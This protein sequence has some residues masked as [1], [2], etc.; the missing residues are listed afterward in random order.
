MSA[1]KFGFDTDRVD[2]LKIAYIGGGSR[3][4]ARALMGDLASEPQMSGEVRLYDIDHGAAKANEII[5]N[6]LKNH[7]GAKGRWDYQAKTSLKD[8]LSGADF[9]VISILP[10]TFEEMQSDVH[11]PEKY[12]IYHSVG[13]TSGPAGI[14]RAMRSIPMFAEIAEAARAYCPSAWV[15]NYTNPMSVCTGAL[16]KIFPEI[17][18]FGCCHEVFH[19]QSVLARM[20]DLDC[21]IKNIRRDEITVNVL[22]IN[23]FTWVTQAG[24]KNIDLMPMFKSFAEKYAE[25]GYAMSEGDKDEN[26]YFRNNNKVCFDLFRRF[27]SAAIPCAGDRHLAEFMPPWYLKNPETVAQWGFG[28]TP[29]PERKKW[30]V[31]HLKNTE[32]LVAGEET[33]NPGNSGEEGTKQIRA[34]LG[35]AEFVTNVNLPNI[36]QGENLPLGAM[37]ETNA[38]FSRDSVRPVFA[39]KL[40][41][42]VNALVSKHAINQQMLIE[43]GVKKDINLA[44]NV[45]LNDS[46]MTLDIKD[47]EKLF[48]EMVRNT[49]KYLDGWDI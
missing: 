3:S 12:G 47:A 39:G 23:H 34:I 24:Y 4:W 40:P 48:G 13:D 18:A 30:L 38:V 27:G 37:I 22:G 33:F 1:N 16:Y 19:I 43:A 46:L 6:T 2:N 29:V 49:K 5:G 42:A 17:K 11:H 28:L 9:V 15:I 35:L 31:N 32:R 21:G 14:V 8:A 26:N 44:F 7:P 20:L 25:S 41:D 36:G 10:G 45:F